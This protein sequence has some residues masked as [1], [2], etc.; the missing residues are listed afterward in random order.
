[1]KPGQVFANHWP[2]SN[3]HFVI[4]FLALEFLGLPFLAGSSQNPLP[5]SP[6]DAV[7]PI[8]SDSPSDSWNRIF[9]CLFT[10]RIAARVS[11]E[12]P[13]GA[14]FTE[15]RESSQFRVS[16]R[17]IDRLEIG[18]RAI[19]SLYPNFFS[20]TGAR[21]VLTE[22]KYSELVK[23]LQ[24]ALDEDAPR[25][26]VARALMQ[27]DLWSAFDQLYGQFTA[28][29]QRELEPHRRVL[30]DLLGRMIKKVA[31]TPQEIQSLP[32]NY[33]AV[34]H[35][36]SLPDIFNKSSGWVEV[37]WFP[38]RQHENSAND[39]RVARVFLKP[40]HPSR[41]LQKF[42]D[43]LRQS[44]ADPVLELDG[45][46][47]VMQP[48][49]IDTQ[50]NLRPTN[51]TTDV[52]I[53]LFEK[54]ASGALKSTKIQVAEISRRLFTA[55][56][57]SGGL[58]PQAENSSA[59]FPSA[60]NDYTFASPQIAASRPPIQ[61][62]LR[63]RCTFCHGQDL[64]QVMTFSIALPPR[65]LT[66]RIRQLDPAAH[67]EADYVASQKQSRKDFKILRTYFILGSK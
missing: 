14:P 2:R 10:R 4:S 3:W 38:R 34:M 61:V 42:A 31:L 28:P 17:T 65:L 57:A 13:E 51:L 15:F 23:A 62:H 22:P 66:P 8:Y 9:Y 41:D 64:T 50:G 29:D 44:D 20:A 46:A 53:R 21:V 45:V 5:Q 43:D 55:D 11:S 33:S 56:P 47:L 18:D 52:Q 25:S 48:L 59:Y 12:Y 7:Q 63:T 67:Q 40:T 30:A 36:Q 26:P 49:L 24:D 54:T 1:M 32:A 27:S 58:A 16:T 6:R 37:L 39:R 19:D 35:R 60:G